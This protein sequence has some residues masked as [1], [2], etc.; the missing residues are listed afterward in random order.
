M[1]RTLCVLACVGLVPAF[2]AIGFS[3]SDKCQAI[4]VNK[5][6]VDYCY[7][8]GGSQDEARNAAPQSC[9]EG[10]QM[11]C[12]SCNACIAFAQATD[13]GTCWAGDWGMTE[14]EAEGKA[15]KACESVGC[16]CEIKFKKC[17]K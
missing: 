12:W 16:K 7:E 11:G 9:G 4:Y 14:E 13:G 6:N 2:T 1:A 8:I 5:N 10:S 15:V 3:Q 17:L